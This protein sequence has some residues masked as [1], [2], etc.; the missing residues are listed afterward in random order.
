VVQCVI[1]GT[2]TTVQIRLVIVVIVIAAV[3]VMAGT[4]PIAAVMLVSAAGTAGA[5]LTARLANTTRS[6]LK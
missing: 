6:Q 4:P 1:P 5:D 3:L 2:K